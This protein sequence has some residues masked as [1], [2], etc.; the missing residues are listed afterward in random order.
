MEWL[1]TACDV[2]P[3]SCLVQS[4]GADG[5]TVGEVGAESRCKSGSKFTPCC[6]EKHV[7]VKSVINWQDFVL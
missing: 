4:L 2:S 3:M 7:E 6:R 1:L 5:R